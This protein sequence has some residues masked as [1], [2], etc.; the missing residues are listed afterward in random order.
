MSLA[1]AEM[2][3]ARQAGESGPDMTAME[4]LFQLYRNHVIK[5]RVAAAGES[6]AAGRLAIET[7]LFYGRQRQLMGLPEDSVTEAVDLMPTMARVCLQEESGPR[8]TMAKSIST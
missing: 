7:V 3:R 5:P 2:V 6:C 4:Y 8:R 1:S